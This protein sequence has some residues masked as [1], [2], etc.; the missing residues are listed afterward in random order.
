MSLICFV[1]LIFLNLILVHSESFTSTSHLTHLF[2]TEIELS[3]QL[4]KYLKDEYERL[5]QVEKFLNVI[6]DE[7][8]QAQGN[9]ERYFGNP[10]N[11]YL[12]IKHLT[13]EWY[14]VE[15]IVSMDISKTMGDNWAFPSFEDYTGSA[16]ALMRLQD[17]YKLNTSDLANGKIS[18]NFKS[19][20]LSASECY[21]LGRIAYTNADFYHT[22]MWMQEALD[23]LDR[24]TNATAPNKIDILDHLAY[25]TSQQGNIEHALALTEEILAIAP[26]HTRALNN[27]EYYVDLLRKKT[28]KTDGSSIVNVKK[29]DLSNI[30]NQRPTDYLE[31]REQYEKLCRQTESK[32]SPKQQAKLFCR[33]RHNNHPYLILRPV[34]EE[35]LLDDPALYLY[36]DVITDRDIDEIKALAS[37]RL[38][39]AVVRD[40]GTSSLKAADYRIS[41]SAWLK[42]ED[43]PSIARLSRLIEA[44]T[45]LSMLTAEDLQVANYGIGGHYEP[46]FDFA[47]K[48][49]KDAF[50]SFGA[51]NRMATWL[52]YFSDVEQG[53][54]T[55]FP[56]RGGYVKPKK[57]SAAFWYN[58]YASGEGDYTTRHAACP[59][60]IG[61]K[62]VGNKWIHERGQ[63]FRR[64]CSLDPMA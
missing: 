14:N 52:T 6:K 13:V 3:K 25:A 2:N 20:A 8:R 36:H 64:R 54:A 61:N 35:Q 38:Q 41:K 58:L 34:R 42:N 59:V 45:N 56:A 39:R 63:E 55:V 28:S 43:A 46:H 29:V 1:Y 11:S 40:S 47:R 51:G 60:L 7:I 15:E 5:D 32:L 9:P 22:I 21:D 12:F 57:G 27:K 31:E 19:R 26:E 18:D 23:H 33:Y 4:E 48:T 37:P 49:E 44:L 24:E 53:G 10:V 62:W 16:I 17:T 30:K 50:T